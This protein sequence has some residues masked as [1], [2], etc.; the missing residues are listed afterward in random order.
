MNYSIYYKNKCLFS[1]LSLKA[2]KD[3]KEHYDY[4]DK[5]IIKEIKSER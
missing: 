4:D 5:W 3:L 1:E 2:A